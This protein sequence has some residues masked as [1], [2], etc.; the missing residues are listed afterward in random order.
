VS[1]DGSF[2]LYS[3]ARWLG[4]LAA[5]A[6]VGVATLRRA[7]L[8]R[9]G[10]APDPA[11][12]LHHIGLLG[13]VALAVSLSARLYFQTRSL[14]EPEDPVT[15]EFVGLVLE[16][17]W[18]HGWLAQATAA[19]AAFLTW[20]WIGRRPGSA[21]A[22]GSALV[23]AGA[24][25]VAAPFTGHAV[26]LAGAPWYAPLLDLVHFGAGAAWL[27]TLAMLVVVLRTR[28]ADAAL[29]GGAPSAGG[30]RGLVEAFSPV[31]LT[32]GVIA[33]ASGGILAFT[34]L[35][36]IAPLFETVYG[37]MVLIKLGAIGVTAGLG[38]YNWRSVLPRL[39]AGTPA[40][41]LQTATAEAIVGAIILACT[42]VLV[43]LPAPGESAE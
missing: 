14:L 27:G 37:R 30:V 7:V 25:A 24:I 23:A 11:S 16:S 3:A 34:Y 29:T 42:A 22:A 17:R 31:A 43:S 33:M 4:Y 20:I 5:F 6:I 10:A 8:P 40:P 15:A 21:L 13:L 12:P 39:R 28:V 1:W 2:L 18:G 35:G 26:G 9:S 32:A 19:V 41:V 38:A 36:G